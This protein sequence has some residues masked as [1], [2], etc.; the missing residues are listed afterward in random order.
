MDGSDLSTLRTSS[1]CLKFFFDEQNM[2]NSINTFSLSRFFVRI[3]IA[4]LL[5]LTGLAARADGT[6]PSVVGYTY[7]TSGVITLGADVAGFPTVTRVNFYVDGVLKGSLTAPSGP[8]WTLAFDST[9]VGNGYHALTI[10]ASDGAGN[11]ASYNGGFN[12]G[13]SDTTPPTVSLAQRGTREFIYFTPTASDLNGIQQLDLFVDG[14]LKFSLTV[15]SY[16]WRS[17]AKTWD[18]SFDSTTLAN[19]NHTLTANAYDPNWNMGVAA[20]L[21]F[22]VANVDT[23]APSITASEVGTKGSITLNANATDNV[24]VSKVEFYVDGVLKSTR[25]AAPWSATLDS[26]TLPNGNHALIAKAYDIVGNVG[27][28]ASVSFSIDN[29][30]TQ[31]PTVG[32]SVSGNSGIVTFTANATD[33]VGVSKVEIYINGA[34]KTTLTSAPWT[35]TFDTRA[36]MNG[37][38]PMSAK[39]YDAA[40][41]VGTYASNFNVT[42]VDKDPPVVTASVLGRS[43]T[44]TLHYTASDNVAVATLHTYIDGNE[45]ALP[46]GSSANGDLSY[47]SSH[48]ADGDHT[49]TVKAYD[50]AGNL[51]TAT[52]AFTTDNRDYQAPIV[53]ASVTQKLNGIFITSSPTDNRG[54]AQVDFYVDGKL[55]GSATAAPWNLNLS[56]DVVSGGQHVLVAKAFDA[57]RNAGSSPSIPF[58][59]D[60]QPPQASVKVFPSGKVNEFI[61]ELHGTDDV[62]VV[63][64]SLLLDGIYAVG[65]CIGDSGRITYGMAGRGSGLHYLE[66]TAIDAVGRITHSG[67]VTFLVDGPPVVVTLNPLRVT[68]SPGAKQAFQALVTGTTQSTVNWSATGGSITEN[69]VFTAPML[70]GTYNVNATSTQVPNS[71]AQATIIVTENPGIQVVVQPGDVTLLP[72]ATQT[73]TA[74]VTGIDNTAVTWSTSDGSISN[75][76]TFTAP[77][78][79]GVYTITATSVADSTRSGYATVTISGGLGTPIG[80]GTLT[81]TRDVMYMG[82]QE[83]GEFNKDGLHVTHVDH[84]GSPRCITGPD[85]SQTPNSEQKFLPFGET[86]NDPTAFKT[87]K[88]FTNHEQTDASGL[89]YMQARFYAP[90]YH[91][92][93]SPDPAKDQKFQKPQSLNIYSYVQN[94]PI[95]HFDPS[96]CIDEEIR[97]RR[98]EDRKGSRENPINLGGT[99]VAVEDEAPFRVNR[100]RDQ[101]LRSYTEQDLWIHA[102]RQGTVRFIGWQDPNDHNKGAGFYIKIETTDSNGQIDG[103]DV[104]GH[105]DPNS[106]YLMVGDTVEA[107]DEIGFVNVPQVAN[108]GNGNTDG[109]TGIHLHWERREGKDRRIVNPGPS[110]LRGR[111]SIRDRIGDVR[112]YRHGRPHGGVDI[113]PSPDIT[114]EPLQR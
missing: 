83:V 56:T 10:E 40:G 46:G 55:M 7:G 58:V 100:G 2:S 27:T 37:G 47:D 49:F 19:G 18:L 77:A 30:D 93:M 36:L 67:P 1:A 24:G 23:Q 13:N 73:F 96:G 51:G 66:A 65:G 98:N 71:G 44:I 20:P 94:S 54:I 78:T 104:Y 38:Y 15:P 50:P 92:F 79:P 43:G 5:S 14:D 84:L 86:L 102:A 114:G 106:I 74:T 69:G 12:S 26:K 113:A 103:Y 33:N 64:M 59:V 70:P 57:A 32:L 31:P 89:I 111:K 101:R 42:N 110:P 97:P 99:T 75:T 8:S 91:R 76:G 95:D 34:L 17:G 39:A 35:M 29:G 6:P 68:M 45:L 108:Q 81:W 61:F 105:T 11:T 22:T 107:G 9:T 87:A 72:G 21:V 62:G 52:A 112:G 25:T 63:S 80:G 48:L 28:S 16:E 53:T 60:V 41:N 88:G 90:V 85:G 109:V 3:Y 4:I 82:T